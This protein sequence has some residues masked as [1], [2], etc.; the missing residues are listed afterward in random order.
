M[1]SSPQDV[2]SVIGTYLFTNESYSTIK[3]SKEQLNNELARARVTESSLDLFAIGSKFI[4]NSMEGNFNN[5]VVI[6]D[7]CSCLYNEDLA[8]AF[9]NKGASCYLA[10]DAT[11]DLDYVDRATAYLIEQLCIKKVT[12]GNAVTSTMNVIGPDPKYHAVLNY[13]PAQNPAQSG[14]K[15]LKELI[16]E[17][18]ATKPH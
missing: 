13:Y 2:E 3:Y 12:V 10:W 15:T 18:I 4:N 8:Q 7:G 5:T 6:I 14:D 17:D 9:I 16:K 1:G 11:V